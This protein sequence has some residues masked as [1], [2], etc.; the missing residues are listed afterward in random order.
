MCHWLT[1]INSGRALEKGKCVDMTSGEPTERNPGSLA[2]TACILNADI[3]ADQ[4]RNLTAIWLIVAAGLP[5]AILIKFSGWDNLFR[6][7]SAAA[8]MAGTIVVC[9]AENILQQKDDGFELWKQA[10][11]RIKGKLIKR[12]K[13][14]LRWRPSLSQLRWRPLLNQLM[15]WSSKTEDPAFVM[16]ETVFLGSVLFFV[17]NMYFAATD[18]DIAHS[19]VDWVQVAVFFGAVTVLPIIR[20]AFTKY[21]EDYTVNTSLAGTWTEFSVWSRHMKSDK[22]LRRATKMLEA[23]QPALAIPLLEEARTLLKRIPDPYCEAQSLRLLADAYRA[24]GQ[25]D[26][27]ASVLRSAADILGRSSQSD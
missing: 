13:S 15:P 23:R 18:R 17:W 16:L 25:T 9:V 24:A 20:F 6:S 11:S 22:L 12:L 4:R 14:L 21:Q 19:T 27:A 2:P 8:F 5:F 1:K 7:G 26:N 10:W 3:K